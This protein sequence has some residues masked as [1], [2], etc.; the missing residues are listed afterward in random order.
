MSKIGASPPGP[1]PTATSATP[2]GTQAP[3]AG[4]VDPAVPFDAGAAA[5]DAA[6]NVVGEADT[7]ERALPATLFDAPK[8]PRVLDGDAVVARAGAAYDQLPADLQDKMSQSVWKTLEPRQRQNLVTI[9]N[10]LQEH[11][12]WDQVKRVVGEKDAPEPYA[13]GG[14]FE[15]AGNSGGI[16]FEAVDAGALV[17]K[18][19]DTGFFGEDNKWIALLHPGQRSLR[20]GGTGNVTSLHVSVGPG[21]L[22]D[23]HVDKFSPTQ[24]PENG[25]TQLDPF[26]ALRHHNNEVWPELV[27]NSIGIPGF[28]V[29]VQ[30]GSR[31]G[32]EPVT[33]GVGIELRWPARPGK[34]DPAFTRFPSAEGR[35]PAADV[36]A[37]I[38]DQVTA[39][40]ISLPVPAGLAAA[41]VPSA[42]HLSE[43]LAA[44]VMEAAREGKASVALDLPQYAHLASHQDAVLGAVRQIGAIVHAEM[45]AARD[46]LPADERARTPS[47]ADVRHVEVTFG[48]RN[49]QGLATQGGKVQLPAL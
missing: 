39:K 38:A 4:K 10:G 44:L 46:A 8:G 15:V 18:L 25:A 3:Q 21:N 36:L 17:G 13:F 1:P 14:R 9:Y 20:E 19:K 34:P 32:K 40:G 5:R 7:F 12:L 37:K 30:P 27:R 24:K 26:G 29:R 28:G 22:F 2:P 45:T 6:A 41:D 33:L 31:E 47:V 43:S 35:P 11:G 48:V 42:R 23:A 16:A 49:A